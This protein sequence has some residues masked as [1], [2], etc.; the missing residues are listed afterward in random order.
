MIGSSELH[1]IIKL[2]DDTDPEVLVIVEQKLLS[3]ADSIVDELEKIWLEN[4]YSDLNPRIEEILKL[5]QKRKLHQD[6]KNWLKGDIQTALSAWVL[7]SRI[8]YPGLTLG[9]V[10]SHL[11]QLKIDAWI[12]LSGV[13]NPLDQINVLNH[14]I[15][16]A[17]GFK[18]NNDNY[19][20]PDNSI[21]TRVLE[22]KTGN[23][24]SLAVLYMSLANDL[25]IPLFGINLPQ[26]FILGYCRLHS[27][28]DDN[29]YYKTTDI[30]ND[31]VS[32]VLFYL[33]PF[34]KGQIFSQESIDAFLKVINVDEQ[35][36]FYHPCEA[37]D[38]FKRILRNMYFSFGEEKNFIKQEEVAE[39]MEIVGISKPNSSFD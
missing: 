6:I 15:F 18:G 9:M 23:P 1:A 20:D 39:I 16:E 10:R 34:S 27:L 36:A 14:V 11:N 29:G 4:T 28:P 2:L 38:I 22:T 3:E 13:R 24:I 26:H 21:I 31:N 33:N 7:C 17:Y 37:L 8:Q 5:I 30:S 32:S 25:G 12:K 19:H 35:P